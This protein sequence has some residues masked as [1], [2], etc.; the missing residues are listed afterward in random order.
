VVIYPEGTVTKHPDSLPME[1]KTGAVP[2]L[3]RVGRPRH[4]MASWGGQAV[5][6]KSGRA[7]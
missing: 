2:A 5:W 7:R 3:A 1:G 6:Q 4:P